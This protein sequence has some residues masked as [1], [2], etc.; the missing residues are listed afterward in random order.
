MA[1]NPAGGA[2]MCCTAAALVL[3]SPEP[4]SCS[5]AAGG[6]W[7]CCSLQ[8]FVLFGA[9]LSKSKSSLSQ[10]VLFESLASTACLRAAAGCACWGLATGDRLP[11][12][13]PCICVRDNNIVHRFMVPAKTGS[14]PAAGCVVGTSTSKLGAATGKQGIEKHTQSRNW[15]YLTMR[16][17]QVLLLLHEV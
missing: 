15:S 1:A 13:K 5:A 9:Q 3:A 6:G 17:M 10:L 16:G 8:I 11:W 12:H 14:V 2:H 7:Y 4:A